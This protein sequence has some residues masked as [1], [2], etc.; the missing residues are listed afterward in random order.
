VTALCYFEELWVH[1][2]YGSEHLPKSPK[3]DFGFELYNE[4][5]VQELARAVRL[6][7]KLRESDEN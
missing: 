7:Q 1:S 4:A 3:T 6:R 5:Y 2:S